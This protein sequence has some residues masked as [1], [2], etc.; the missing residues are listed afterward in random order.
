MP[1]VTLRE[2]TERPVT[3][4]EGSNVLAGTSSERIVALAQDAIRTGGRRGRQPHLW[5][6]NAAERIVNVL[7]AR[8]TA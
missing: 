4:D 6:G 5:D 7:A 8:L 1:C 3:V 2:N